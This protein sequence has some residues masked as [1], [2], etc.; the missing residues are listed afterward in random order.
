MEKKVKRKSKIF[1]K[2]DNF[3]GNSYQHFLCYLPA[4]IGRV[5]DFFLRIFFSGIHVDE[6]QISIIKELRK[7]GI[8]IYASKY[9]SRFEF[10]FYYTRYKKLGLPFPEIAL[11]YN[12]VLLQPVKRV[13]KIIVSYLTFF[14]HNFSFPTPYKSGYL[15]KEI[16][17][18]EKTA[19]FSLIGKKGFYNRFIKLQPGPLQQLIQIQKTTLKPIYIIPQLIFFTKKRPNKASFLNLIQGT[20]E[21]P[22]IVRRIINLFKNYNKISVETS[23]YF[24]LKEFLLKEEIKDIG[25]ERQAA[26]VEKILIDIINRHRQSV[27]GPIAKSIQ[28]IKQSI[29][30]KKSLNDFMEE[31]CKTENKNIHEVRKKADEYLNEIA[32]TYSKVLIKIADFTAAFIFKQMFDQ[33]IVNK[34]KVAKIREMAKRGPL[35]IIPCHKS[36]MDYLIINHIIYKSGIP[37]PQIAAGKN[38]SFW[39][40]GSIFRRAGAFFIRR[41][42]KGANLYVKVFAEYIY[43][44]IEEGFNIEFY[45]EGTRS[46]TGKL[47]RPKLGLLSILIDACKNGACSDLVFAPV[48]IGYDRVV[49][50]QAYINEIEGG[51]KKPEDLK[52]VIKARKSV[53]KR[54]GKVYIKFS[55]PIALKDVLENRDNKNISNADMAVIC[56][57]IGDRVLSA[58]DKETVVT[59][60]SL[61]SAAILNLRGSTV[62]DEYI[63]AGVRRYLEYLYYIEAKMSD[64]LI[65]AN[66]AIKVVIDA[67]V[68]RKFIQH[69]ESD[70]EEV[71]LT[72]YSINESKR[73]MLDYYKN[74]SIILFI[75]IIFTS[76]AILKQEK[77]YFPI[78]DIYNNY[79]WLQDLFKNEFTYNFIKSPEQLADNSINFLISQNIIKPRDEANGEYG[80]ASIDIGLIKEYGRFLKIFLE[81]YYIVIS[82]LSKYSEKLHDPKDRIK[83]IRIVGRLMFKRKEVE[84]SEALSKINYQNALDYFLFNDFLRHKEKIY[85]YLEE[86]KDYL[87]L[88][89]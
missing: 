17:D 56:Q 60:Y 85:Y 18:K 65:S 79:K 82:Y 64:A 42:F 55:D 1:K 27:T 29:L 57:S 4:K 61:V 22:G 37:L 75:P 20:I 9:K 77:L 52:Q 67:Y 3:L 40:M 30:T 76:L 69:I 35:I 78:Q 31:Y 19:F 25:S 51:E 68:N 83:K 16:A 87:R 5:A 32:A 58:I 49:E 13:I 43:K 84:L 45:I 34:K 50:E 73:M 66:H 70:K 11:D 89:Q 21:N 33:I 2:I 15:R 54:Y 86:I 47:L 6:S 14:L 8:I 26:A 7:D 41:V 80:L 38:L 71:G 48:F 10:F 23:Q 72:Y 62:S 36:H 63:A 24:N 46:R 88:I 28:E 59:P 39:P 74:N 81:S 44:I 53:K 12:I